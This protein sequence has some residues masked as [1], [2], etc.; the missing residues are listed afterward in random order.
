MH[1][2]DCPMC[3]GDHCGQYECPFTPEQLTQMGITNVHTNMD[4]RR[5][6]NRLAAGS[7]DQLPAANDLK[8]LKE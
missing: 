8:I 1:V 7:L 2:K 3:G 6:A 5:S 4:T